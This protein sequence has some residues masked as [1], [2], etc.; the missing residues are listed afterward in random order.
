MEFQQIRNAT[1][2]ITYAEKKFLVSV[3]RGRGY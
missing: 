2:T 3:S 1:I